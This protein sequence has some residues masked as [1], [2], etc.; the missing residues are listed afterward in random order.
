ML[1]EYNERTANKILDL[2]TRQHY[3][4]VAGY[5]KLKLTEIMQTAK[6]IKNVLHHVLCK[7]LANNIQLCLS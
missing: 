2:T 7:L 1:F 4:I 6:D 3:F 5:S